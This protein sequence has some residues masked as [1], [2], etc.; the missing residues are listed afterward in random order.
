[1]RVL[2]TLL[3]GQV[4]V[5]MAFM[6]VCSM[7]SLTAWAQEDGDVLLYDFEE[8]V[9]FRKVW[10]PDYTVA[11]QSKDWAASGKASLRLD[12][13]AWNND[14][15]G[16]AYY[17]GV[18]L[19]LPRQRDWS[20]Y[21]YLTVDVRSLQDDTPFSVLVQ[22]SGNRQDRASRAFG[23]ATGEYRLW[24]SIPK[25]LAAGEPQPVKSITT[26]EFHLTR[27]PHDAVVYVDN[28]R[29]RRGDVAFGEGRLEATTQQVLAELR[30]QG[31]SA[32]ALGEPAD[33]MQRMDDPAALRTAVMEGLTRS[34]RLKR[35]V[36]ET[37]S[38]VDKNYAQSGYAVLAT[39]AQDRVKIR[40]QGVLSRW[41]TDAS[42]DLMRGE[43]RSFQMLLIPRP[44]TELKNVQVTLPDLVSDEK[45][46]IE[47]S[48]L[49]LGV[50]GY[51]NLPGSA[52]MRK[53]DAPPGWY[54]D[55]ILEWTG[56]VDVVSPREAQPLLVT[57]SVPR[58][59]TPG[60]YTGGIHVQPEGAKPL[61]LPLSVRVRSVAVPRGPR[62]PHLVAIS[63]QQNPETGE[64]DRD[65][66]FFLS[67][68][69]NPNYHGLG[70][71]YDRRNGVAGTP[72]NTPLGIDELKRYVDAGMNRFNLCEIMHRHVEAAFKNGE[73]G[74]QRY[75]NRIY[76]MYTD[77]YME[78]LAAAGLADKAVF[79]GF[80]EY[81]LVGDAHEPQR[82]R[83]TRIFGALRERYGKY[84][85]KTATTARHWHGD[86]AIDLPVDIWIPIG[87]L[88]DPD[89]GLARVAKEQKDV[90]IWWYTIMWDIW[91][92][93]ACSRATPWA[94]FGQGADGWLYYN[95]NGPWQPTGQTLGEAPL[96]AWQAVSTGTYG[97][98]G[99]GSLVYHDAQYRMR[100][101]LRLVNFRDGMYDYD[102]LAMLA[103]EVTRL[104]GR[105]KSL[106]F[107]QR[108]D[109]ER[110][111]DIAVTRDWQAKV[112]P[113]RIL[114]GMDA[115]WRLRENAAELAAKTMNDIRAE[116][117]DLLERFQAIE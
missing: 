113:N 17:P 87:G 21:D 43:T 106:S 63:Q 92:A 37:A 60:T 13:K 12:V 49:L 47:A 110:A 83:L 81:P 56:R 82:R 73:E 25:L 103:D 4:P 6:A 31:V 95:L 38:F 68:R 77:E 53:Y 80:D 59:C 41:R 99:T 84:G 55:P 78:K 91:Q 39:D 107:A 71:I 48:Q 16:A 30:E 90:E 7:V 72:A 3:R 19:N 100:P 93:P 29:L 27:V 40:G 58:D 44:G 61:D 23:L 36:Q 108:A 26:F 46:R 112:W 62:M 52:T 5:T 94:T 96:T 2:Q 86:G 67:F 70:G 105:R 32:V 8:G 85:V 115:D 1:M 109:L 111:R 76:R 102:I 50:V 54:A 74:V 24:L 42:L 117:L 66:E 114:K 65:P 88:R 10:S 98:H 33:Y 45:G 97:L 75:L 11:E 34:L 51:V 28:I 101:S 15:H 22:R 89:S 69:I 20:D 35:T 64:K 9:S 57:V 14:L 104:D 18:N 79:Y 116:S